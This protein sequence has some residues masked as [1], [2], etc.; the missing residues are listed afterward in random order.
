MQ[1]EGFL[2]GTRKRLRSR[3]RLQPALPVLRYAVRLVEKRRRRP[4]VD[5]ILDRVAE[6]R[7]PHV[8]LTG[9]E[10]MLFAELIPLTA[11]LHPGT[12]HHDRNGWHVYLP[13]TC[14]LMSFSPKLANSTPTVERAGP[15]AADTSETGMSRRW[16]DD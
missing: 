12:A 6:P 16:C 8:V 11:G 1:G 9:G 2:T 5:E 10:P 3:Q 13:V 4:A 15:W 7:Q 14:D